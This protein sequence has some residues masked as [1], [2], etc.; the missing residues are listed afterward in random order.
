MLS[1]AKFAEEQF[2]RSASGYKRA[3]ETQLLAALARALGV[4]DLGAFRPRV[5]RINHWED[6]LPVKTPPASRGCLFDVEQGLGWCGDFCVTPGIQGAALS[7]R[8]MAQTL[9]AFLEGPGAFDRS[10]LLPADEAWV[11]IGGGATASAVLDM[12][13]FARSLGLRPC[14]THTDL[15]PS[16][17]GGYDKAAQLGGGGYANGRDSKP[18]KGKGKGKGD[19]ERRRAPDG[20][21]YTKVEFKRFFGSDREWE[22]ALGA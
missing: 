5:N 12:G 1:T 20:K 14:S 6:G 13:A 11:P 16:A 21:A 17:I 9:Q 3:A 19:S 18:G 4:P 22:M 10:G 8:V 2:Q 7:G 15:V